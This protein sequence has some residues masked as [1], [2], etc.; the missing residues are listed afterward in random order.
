MSVCVRPARPEDSGDIL[1][2]L[3]LLAAFEGEPD[4]VVTT[5]DTIRAD[6][7]GPERRFEALLAEVDGAVRGMAV[8]YQA[9]SSWRGAPTLV[10][11]DLFVDEAARG[12]GAGKTL[13]SA[14]AALAMER[15][16]CRMDVNVVAWN[17][18]GRKF[19]ERQGFAALPDWLPHRLDRQG[20]ERLVGAGRIG[21]QGGQPPCG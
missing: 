3:R 20:M 9:Y 16:C 15:G 17:A 7:F 11:H 10:V 12:T 1:R 18:E 2:L 19:Y 13:L 8:L 6:G 21:G 5:E 4:G 14:A